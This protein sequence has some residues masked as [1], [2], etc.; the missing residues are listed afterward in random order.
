MFAGI[1]FLP[2]NPKSSPTVEGGGGSLRKT[3]PLSPF[4]PLVLGRSPFIPS[5]S[6]SHCGGDGGRREKEEEGAV[7]GGAFV[8]SPHPAM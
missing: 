3:N 1:F 4:S 5:S 2:R 6:R 8:L 7:S